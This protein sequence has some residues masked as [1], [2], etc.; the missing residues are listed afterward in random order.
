MSE[1]MKLLGEVEKL[2]GKE[3][4]IGKQHFLLLTQCFQKVSFSGCQK[5]ALCGKG[6][7]TFFLCLVNSFPNDKLFS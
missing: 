3:E 5:A 6:L 4:N 2:V 7:N 1:N